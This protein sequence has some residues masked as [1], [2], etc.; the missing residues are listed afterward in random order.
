M[1][2][3]DFFTTMAAAGTF[4]A[5]GR[6]ALAAPEGWRRFEITYRLNLQEQ[7]TPARVWVPVPQ[8]ALDYQRVI[9]LSWRSPVPTFVLWERAS[10]API[11]SAAWMESTS[12]RD[13]EITAQVANRD[14]AGFCPDISTEERAEYLRPTASSPTDGIVFAKAREIVGACVIGGG[15]L[16]VDGRVLRLF[17]QVS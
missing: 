3:R 15:L 16:I 17:R 12:P 7:K 9:D 8:D 6:G 4:A 14:R 10:R 2:R 5:L 1:L 13:V 11:V